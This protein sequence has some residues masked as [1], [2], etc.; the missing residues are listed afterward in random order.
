MTELMQRWEGVSLP[1]NLFLEKWLGGDESGAF[2]QTSLQGRPATVK[3]IPEASAATASQLDLWQR[4]RQLRHPNLL[5]L[6]DYGRAELS[7]EIVLFAVFEAHDDTLASALAHSPLSSAEARE[8]LDS[9]LDAL[10]YLHA[11]GFVAGVLD[12]DHILAVGERIKLS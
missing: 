4:T 6:V 2:F 10:A 5:E 9:V 11:Q 12:P 1:G 3:L 7:G 8:V